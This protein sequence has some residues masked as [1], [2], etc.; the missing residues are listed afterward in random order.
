MITNQVFNIIVW[1]W[2]G[3]ALCLFPILFK[4]TAPYGRYSNKHWGPMINNQLG[5]FLMELPALAV[6]VFFIL[7]FKRLENRVVLIASGLW[8][9]HYFHRVVI[10]PFRIRTGSKKMPVVILMFAFIFNLIN[11]SINGYWL[12]YLYTESDPDCGIT[13]FRI[14]AG[15]VLFVTG[16]IINLYHDRLLIRLRKTSQNGYKIPYGGLFQYTS[17][18]NFFGEI[19]EWGGFALFCWGMP[20]L[21]FFIWTFVNLLPR[22]LDHHKWYKKNFT[23]YPKGRKAVIPFIL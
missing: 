16:F 19:I 12:G 11:G 5:W 10:Y 23:D 1:S 13:Y 20:S 7:H 14:I 2:I 15:S 9:A 18:P 4:V 6:F 22:A 21:S 17:C 8:I 3:F